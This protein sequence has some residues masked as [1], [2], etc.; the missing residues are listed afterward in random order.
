[1]RSLVA[2]VSVALV[3]LVAAPVGAQAPPADTVTQVIRQKARQDMTSQYEAGRKKHMAWHKAQNDTWAW[4]VFEIMTGPDTGG[5]IIASGNHQWADFDTWLAKMGDGDTA[6]AAASMAGT[7][8]GSETSYWTQLNAISRLPPVNERSPLLSL[9]IYSVKPGHDAALTATIGKLNTALTGAKYP[10]HS[11]WYRLTNGGATP[12]YAVVTPRANMASFGEA[13][14]TAIEK[15]LGKAGSDA[16]VK[17]FFDNVT[18]VTTELLQRRP[19]LSYVP[20]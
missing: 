10:L 16:L 1:M 7:Q 3:A 13:V 4:D 18:G 6:D 8:G 12:A 14:M 19:D 11:V 5:Y 2:S 20:N 15:Q 9:T 17:E